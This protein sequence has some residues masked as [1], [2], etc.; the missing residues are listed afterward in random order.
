MC[1]EKKHML[2]VF[3]ANVWTFF[4]ASVTKL[5]DCERTAES[6]GRRFV[7]ACND[8][9]S[10]MVGTTKRSSENDGQHFAEGYLAWFLSGRPANAPLGEAS[11]SRPE[12]CAYTQSKECSLGASDPKHQ[13]PKSLTDLKRKAVRA[14]EATVASLP[15]KK[16][17]KKTA[18]V[19][20][21]EEPLES[22]SKVGNRFLVAP[23]KRFAFEPS[24]SQMW[25][26]WAE[27]VVQNDQILRLVSTKGG[28]RRETINASGNDVADKLIARQGKGKRWPE[29]ERLGFLYLSNGSFNAV[30]KHECKA[31]TT[32][33]NNILPKL[34]CANVALGNCVLRVPVGWDSFENVVT[35][36][37]NM[38]EAAGSGYGPLIAGAWVGSCSQGHK[39]FAVL[40]RGN[41]DWS[42]RLGQC[43]VTPLRSAPV[44]LERAFQ[45][46]SNCIWQ[47]SANRCVFFD[48]KPANLID[49]FPVDMDTCNGAVKVIDMDSN[50]FR[51]L[52]SASPPGSQGW[53][54]VWLFNV[55]FVSVFLRAALPDAVYKVWWN[56]HKNAV[57]HTLELIKQSSLLRLDEDYQRSRRFLI[58]AKW[59]GGFYMKR[60]MPPSQ[61]GTDPEAVASTAVNFCTH[62]FH[63]APYRMATD[64]I[65]KKM[66][67]K[68]PADAMDYYE[69]K[70]L[71]R[72]LPMCRFFEEHMSPSL[73]NAPLLVEV[74]KDF[75]AMSNQDLVCLVDPPKSTCW[76]APNAYW[77]RALA[78]SE[79]HSVD[80]NSQPAVLEALGFSRRL[81]VSLPI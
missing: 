25:Y 68:L 48:A 61:Q 34:I 43:D 6:W 50:S 35:E 51:R 13:H 5:P 23:Q 11:Q 63:D 53:R 52:A 33:L 8:V 54:G 10:Q 75:C 31:T 16:L 15:P 74:M 36:L 28:P 47:I 2:P 9:R 18:D 46:L 14:F 38:A 27:S 4:T 29:F 69:T 49:T 22:A 12:L 77:K 41:A 60:E 81:G 64:N 71:T 24:D 39:L 66:K 76:R 32:S 17:A 73:S 67:R 21:T 57:S 1:A 72:M 65:V 58:A 42:Q 3:K 37:A 44:A 56:K 79:L 70:W 80:W 55:L 40:Q 45:S 19:G 59:T 78:P 62:Y 30:F 26:E 20:I 7:E